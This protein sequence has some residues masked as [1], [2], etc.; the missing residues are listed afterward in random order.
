ML[1]HFSHVQLYATPWTVARQAP[2]SIWFSRQEYWNGLPCPP[3]GDLPN[4][5]TEPTSLTCHALAGSFSTTSASWEDPW[6]LHICHHFKTKDVF[7]TFFSYFFSFGQKEGMKFCKC[8]K[9]QFRYLNLTFCSQSIF[10]IKFTSPSWSDLNKA[11]H[12]SYTIFPPSLN[13]RS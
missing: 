3:P 5:G 1:S 9:I 13:L 7:S 8:L 4:P 10:Y 6:E 2:L 11:Q 12:N